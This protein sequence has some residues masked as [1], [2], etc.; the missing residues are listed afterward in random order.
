VDVRVV[1]ADGAAAYELALGRDIAARKRFGAELVGN[2]R[3]AMSGRARSELAGGQVD[4]RVLLA[5]PALAAQHPITII[6]FTDRAPRAGPGV[7]LAV[8]RLAGADSQ[9][10]LSQAAYQR[11][12]LAFLHQQR[13][14]FRP[15]SVTITHARGHPVVVIRYSRPTPLGLLRP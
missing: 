15:L 6:A 3:I 13:A 4:P 8:V 7:P 2:S 11:W 9:A 14:Q 5:L 1:A 10:G 12:L